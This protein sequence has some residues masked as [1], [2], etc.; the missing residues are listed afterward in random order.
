MTFC[1]QLHRLFVPHLE[2]CSTSK[3]MSI[4]DRCATAIAIVA[5]PFERSRIVTAGAG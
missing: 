2:A 1:D 4:R 3:Y 5:R